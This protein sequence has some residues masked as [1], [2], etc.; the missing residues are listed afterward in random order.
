MLDCIGGNSHIR[1]GRFVKTEN[2]QRIWQNDTQ[3]RL[4]DKQHNSVYLQRRNYNSAQYDNNFNEIIKHSFIAIYIHIMY[5][6]MYTYNNMYVKR[7]FSCAQ[8]RGTF[9]CRTAHP[10]GSLGKG[11][12]H[13]TVKGGCMVASRHLPNTLC[14]LNF[15]SLFFY[16]HYYFY[17][18]RFF[19]ANVCL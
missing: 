7:N 9:I 16:Y 8:F 4:L 14:L 2:S 19:L 11:N 3:L 13:Q 5:I 1:G 10:H 18:I 6:A 17:Q 15:V 12:L